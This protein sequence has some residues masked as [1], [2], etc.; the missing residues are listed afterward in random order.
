VLATFFLIF[1]WRKLTDYSGTVS[2]MVKKGAPIPV[3]STVVAIF[4]E[5]PVGFAVAAERSSRRSA[6]G[7]NMTIPVQGGG[8]PRLG[9]LG[10]TPKCSSRRPRRRF[11]QLASIRLWLPRPGAG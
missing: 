6:P 10:T 5:L 9:T 2:Q 8:S 4:M 11:I 3:L 7:I 1:G